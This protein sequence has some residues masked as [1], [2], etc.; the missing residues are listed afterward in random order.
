MKN[1]A[2]NSWMPISTE[3]SNQKSKQIMDNQNNNRTIHQMSLNTQLLAILK[4]KDNHKFSRY[5]AFLWLIEHIL[6]GCSY[7]DQK[8]SCFMQH[9]CSSITELS[10]T[11]HWSRPTTQKFINE[12]M[13][14][15]LLQK[16]RFGNSFAF[17]LTA[18]A[19]AL[20]Q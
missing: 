1:L 7:T 8:R 12:L 16:K 19:E 15:G 11:W 13:G 18:S 4:S 2:N 6:E 5:D 17:S 20:I 9:Y 14:V 10:E 3:S